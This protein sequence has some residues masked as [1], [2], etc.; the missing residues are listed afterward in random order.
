MLVREVLINKKS[1]NTYDTLQV[2]RGLS[3]II[4][5]AFHSSVTLALPKYLGVQ[6]ASWALGGKSGVHFFFVLSGFIIFTAHRKD[7]GNIERVKNFL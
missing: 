2:M 6:V 3:A 4:V 5:V 7:L 1:S